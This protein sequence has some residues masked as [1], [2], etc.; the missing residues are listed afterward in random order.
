VEA[1]DADR[2]AGIVL[3]QGGTGALLRRGIPEDEIGLPRLRET[4][5]R[6][7]ESGP[8]P[9]YFAYRLRYGVR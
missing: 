2:A 5:R 6:V 3:S 8:L 9:W 7:L 1:G 4:A